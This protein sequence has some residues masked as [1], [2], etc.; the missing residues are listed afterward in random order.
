MPPKRAPEEP[1]TALTLRHAFNKALAACESRHDV[2]VPHV[3]F[4]RVWEGL[5]GQFPDL[6]YARFSADEHA[7]KNHLFP[8]SVFESFE[9]ILDPWVKKIAE[10][11]NASA[12]LPKLM[13]QRM[14]ASAYMKRYKDSPVNEDL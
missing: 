14:V 8:A 2:V 5:V 10:A 12:D 1:T 6:G 7:P 9:E 4:S 13:A 11:R 3:D